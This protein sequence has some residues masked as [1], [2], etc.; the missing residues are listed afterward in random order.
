MSKENVEIARSGFSALAR[1]DF[2]SFFSV[3]DEG[4][5]WV[6]PPYAVEPGTRHGT[7]GFRVALDRMRASFA[8]IRLKVDEVIEAGETAVVVTGR[9]TGEGRGSGVQL[10]TPFS[11][12]LTLRSGKVVRY[13][14]F[15]EKAEALEAARS[16]E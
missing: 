6:N 11:S 4:V 1:G 5:E 7:E 13:E 10:E 12:M 16:S 15:R 8:G 9:W 14:W 2:E 3:L